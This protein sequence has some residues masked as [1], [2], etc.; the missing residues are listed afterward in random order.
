MK[1]KV[2]KI[3]PDAIIPNYA[4][5]GDAGL[6]LYSCIDTSLEQ[7]QRMLIPTGIAIELPKEYV[8]LI[9]GKSGLAL[10]NGV[11]ILGGV[12]DSNYRGEIGV[13]VLNNNYDDLVIKKGQKIAQMLIQPIE[14]PQIEEVNELNDTN[15]GENGFGSTGL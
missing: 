11:S 4:L 7:N 13:V 1:L 6:D 12:I 9:W 3:R 5:N 2:K 15:R 14:T 10:K 8:A